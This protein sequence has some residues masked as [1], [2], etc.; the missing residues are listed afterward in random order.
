MN[1]ILVKSAF[2][3]KS[4]SIN[5]EIVARN[6]SSCFIPI[7]NKIK[8][9]LVNR[10]KVK[11]GL[12]WIEKEINKFLGN[13]SIRISTESF[14]KIF[15]SPTRGEGNYPRGG[16]GFPSIEFQGARNTPFFPNDPKRSI[17]RKQG[18]ANIRVN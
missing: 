1:R 12:F 11:K 5:C 13:D 8:I 15:V 10:K 7:A 18:G 16:G 6:L 17:Y 14:N 9:I 2:N 3:S 4:L